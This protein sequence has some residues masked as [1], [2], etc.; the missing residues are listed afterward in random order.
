M[1]TRI[2]T[3]RTRRVFLDGVEIGT[4]QIARDCGETVCRFFSTRIKDDH[5]QFV[6]VVEM[7][8]QLPTLWEQERRSEA[9]LEATAAAIGAR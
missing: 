8:N 1:M 5:W 4:Y 7:R 6:T 3:S 9:S 2:S